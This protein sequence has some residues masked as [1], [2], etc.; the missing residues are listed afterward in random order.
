MGNKY[1]EEEIEIDLIE[2][3]FVLKKRIWIIL[4]SAL[5]GGGIFGAFSKYILTPQYTS[6]AMLYI[7]SKETTLASLADLQIGSQLTKDYTVIVG[8]RPVLQEVTNKLGLN[9]SYKELGNK[10]TINNPSGTRILTLSIEDADPV[11]AKTIVDQVAR[12]AS[13]YIGD[14]MEMVPPKLIEDGEIPSEKTSPHTKRNAMIGAALGMLIVC[15]ITVLQVEMND[16]IRS[17]DDIEKY[18]GLSVLA[19]IPEQNDEKHRKKNNTRTKEG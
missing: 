14:I 12:T 13:D 3:F 18:L 5:I 16:S 9:L 15:G 8:S 11:W 10:L 19:F 17:E 1:D 4:L 2:I 7:L 6:T